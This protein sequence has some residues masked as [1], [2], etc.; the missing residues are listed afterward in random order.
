MRQTR[1]TYWLSLS[2]FLGVAGGLL[3]HVDEMCI[4]DDK[5]P[6]VKRHLVNKHGAPGAREYFTSR[7]A[8]RIDPRTKVYTYSRYL[9]NEHAKFSLRA[10]WTDAQLGFQTTHPGLCNKLELQSSAEYREQP[11]TTIRY[12]NRMDTVKVSLVAMKSPMAGVGKAMAPPALESTLFLCVEPRS[13]VDFHFLCTPG[14]KGEVTYKAWVERSK[15]A[16]KGSKEKP[17]KVTW[18]DSAVFSI[19]ELDS[20]IQRGDVF[21][22][23]NGWVK[24]EPVGDLKQSGFQVSLSKD[25]KSTRTAFWRGALGERQV[26]VD[27]YT[28][29]GAWIGKGLVSVYVATKRK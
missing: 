16:R 17:V 19:P 11:N 24:V 26:P 10:D 3:A 9:V 12:G 27:L 22:E 7:S 23:R 1:M 21:S 8:A 2:A 13:V 4:Y 28:K 29:K 6:N 15:A 20:A 25:A 18:L 14:L 5:D